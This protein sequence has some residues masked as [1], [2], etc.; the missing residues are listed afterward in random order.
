MGDD[1]YHITSSEQIVDDMGW[2]MIC[3]HWVDVTGKGVIVD[4]NVSYHYSHNNKNK[5]NYQAREQTYII[6]V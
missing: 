3:D 4:R 2:V 1:V 5:Q 6:Q